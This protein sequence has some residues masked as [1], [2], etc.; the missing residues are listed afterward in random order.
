MEFKGVDTGFMR[1]GD[2]ILYASDST[3]ATLLD[4]QGLKFLKEKAEA[5]KRKMIRF[6]FHPDAADTLH[7]ML[8][9]Q[10]RD[11]YIRPHK[12]KNKA[13]RTKSYHVVEGRVMLIMFDDGGTVTKEIIL[14]DRQAGEAFYCRFSCEVF[15][16]VR[17]IS[18]VAIFLETINGPFNQI[19]TVFAPWAT[20]DGE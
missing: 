13:N 20:N 6:C 18:D 4:A 10:S 7:E 3:T 12:N 2:E 14:G 16:T 15:H 1:I 8:I 11:T 17:V 9:V 19:D 5:N